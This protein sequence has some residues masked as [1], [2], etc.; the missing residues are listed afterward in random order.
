[1]SEHNNDPKWKG[2][3][4]FK[5]WR[6]RDN[7]YPI[8]TICPWCHGAT[9]ADK[10]PRDCTCPA[11]AIFVFGSNEAGAH[12]AGAAKYA[13]DH[14]GAICG[15]GVGMQGFSYGIPTK[16]FKV[17]TLPLD[18]IAPY[19]DQFLDFARANPDMTFAVTR[20]GCGLAGY[21]DEDIAPLFYGFPDNCIMPP[22]WMAPGL[23]L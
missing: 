22:E 8:N 15:V 7:K 20:I 19:V 18:L 21:K 10:N 1:M 23:A 16:D 4:G 12:G 11:D 3:M 2:T 14:H 6:T 9:G 13:V 5:E 17:N